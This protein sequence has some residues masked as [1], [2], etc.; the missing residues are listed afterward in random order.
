L[1]NKDPLIYWYPADGLQE[2]L[3][4]LN[5]NSENANC[6][7]EYTTVSIVMGVFIVSSLMRTNLF[8]ANLIT[9][10]RTSWDDF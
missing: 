5:S 10:K 7:Y 4:P 2:I 6:A 1:E 3:K 8:V 9:G